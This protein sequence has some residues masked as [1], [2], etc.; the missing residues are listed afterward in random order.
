M[1]QHWIREF[2]AKKMFA[3]YTHTHYDGILLEDVTTLPLLSDGDLFV[4]K[5]DQLFGKRWKYGLVWVKLNAS[6]IQNRFEQHNNSTIT[7]NQTTWVLNTFLVE[8]FVPH[9]A[10]YYLS[11][12]TNR[13][14]D[15]IRFSLMGGIDIEDH[16][17]GMMTLSIGVN[18]TLS[19][20][21][22]INTF[23]LTDDNIIRFIIQFFSFFR[24]YGFVYLETNPFAV[25]E[26][27]TIVCLDMVA[28][29]DDC[30]TFNQRH[31]RWIL[32]LPKA[33]WS[34]I[35]ASE[36]VIRGLDEKTGAS[37]KL[38]ILNPN[39]SIR[40]ILWWGWS[41]VITM[42]TLVNLWYWNE[43]GNYGELSWN[44]TVDD[45][46]AYS[47]VLIEQMLHSQS[48]YPKTLCII[49]GIA[50]FTDINNL[51]VGIKQALLMYKNE[52]V[53]QNI[54]ILVRRWWINDTKALEDFSEFCDTHGFDTVVYDGDTF[55]TA[56][57]H[58][59]HFNR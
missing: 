39:G 41:S 43:I 16:R 33:F 35:Y 11:C 12:T 9:I 52:I 30:E 24:Q 10:E 50:N 21:D 58:T 38:S 7:I 44:P 3:E 42:D 45:N 31:H 23:A 22:I 36:D 46:T 57:L 37:L 32:S 15:V 56:P 40:L 26:D 47:R 54:K 55:L 19:H 25:K 18:D 17:D 20:E 6:D 27:G 51:F 49:W 34:K 48:T 29:I 28:K 14:V 53:E 59:F 2:D 4:I 5:P 13:D 1:A 8:K